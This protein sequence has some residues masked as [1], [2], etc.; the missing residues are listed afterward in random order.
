MGRPQ[1]PLDRD[2]SPVREFAFWL[3]DLRRRA[4]LTY[5]QL[6]RKSRYATSTVQSA[7]AGKRLPTLKVTLAFVRACEGELPQWR[8]YWTQVRRLLD[9]EAPP[10]VSRSVAPPWARGPRL[11]DPAAVSFPARDADKANSW[12]IESFSALLRMD[13]D[14]IEALERRVVVATT[15]GVSEIVTSVSVPRQSQDAG[16][17]DELALELLYGGSME[18]RRQPFGGYFQNVIVLPRPLRAGERHEYAMRLTIPEGQCMTPH[19]VH[20]PYRR[21]DH[22]E[23]RVRFNPDRLPECVWILRDAP[24]ALIY[25]GA[26]TAETVTPDRFGEITISFRD[27]CPG[28]GYGVRWAEAGWNSSGSCPGSGRPVGRGV[29]FTGRMEPY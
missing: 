26:P 10:G 9:E 4:G 29:G 8:E 11:G 13:A 1:K 16:Q 24:A 12:F 27:M 19:Y 17:V 18:R 6:G 20:V 3:R 2:G 5:D 7:A 28:L 25:Q 14:L 23:L 21:S 22:F 15:D